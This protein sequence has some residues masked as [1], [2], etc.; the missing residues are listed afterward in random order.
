VTP[1]HLRD[2]AVTAAVFSL[3]SATWF[4]WALEKPP[5][6]WRP[7]LISGVV[8]SYATVI[9]GL[10]I[11]VLHWRDGTVFD[12]TTSPRFGIVVGIEVV[13]AGVGAKILAARRR[14]ELVPAWIAFVVGVHLFP[15][16]VIIHY[17]WIHVVAA[18]VTVAA[19]V[20]VPIA[21]ARSLSVSAVNGVGAGLA[22]LVGAV[23]ALI[24]ALTW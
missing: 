12:A 14:R 6:P 23:V 21:R 19:L 13:A 16:A 5:R 18:L 24:T 8:V 20:A 2:A 11:A 15:V 1:D 4:G 7:W 3:A 17:A 9:A 22:L 10:V